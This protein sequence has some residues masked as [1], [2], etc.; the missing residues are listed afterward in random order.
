MEETSYKTVRTRISQNDLTRMF[1]DDESGRKWFELARWG[2]KPFC[3]HCGSENV[4]SGVQSGS[5]THRCRE[6]DCARKFSVRV[7]T[8]LESSHIPFHKW[9]IAIYLM[10]TS[11]IRVSTV[12]L[13][14]D[15]KISQKSAWFLAQ[16]IR[17]WIRSSEVSAS[18]ELDSRAIDERS[19][20]DKGGTY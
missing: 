5:M 10:T 12:K 15:L 14:R 9:A 3:P 2:G 17:G 18:P 19:L 20:V 4:Q 16:R 7:G 1:P 11:P 8:A 13:H 6:K